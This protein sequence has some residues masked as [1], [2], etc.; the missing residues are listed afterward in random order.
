MRAIHEHERRRYQQRMR[1]P[2]RS[3]PRE[4]A[5]DLVPIPGLFVAL[6]LVWPMVFGVGPPWWVIAGAGMFGGMA[7]VAAVS[8]IGEPRLAGGS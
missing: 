2:E 4:V 3:S 1:Q 8:A 6:A 5:S 7:V